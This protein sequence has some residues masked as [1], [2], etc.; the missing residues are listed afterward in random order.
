MTPE[1]ALTFFLAILVFAITP[2]PGV[3]ALLSRALVHG[4]GACVGLALGMSAGDLVYLLLACFGLAA[5]AEHAQG[6]FTLI[7]YLGAGYLFYLAWRLWRTPPPDPGAA[8][9]PATPR[10]RHLAGFVQGFLISTSNPKVILFYIAF[11]PTFMDLTRLT[12]VDIGVAA[13]LTLLALM[14]G[15]M[16]V[17][18]GAD[19]ARR[20]LATPAAARGLQRGA[21]GLMAA[22]GL[23]L[24]GRGH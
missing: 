10:G 21:G 13:L 7:R 16:S 8:A 5:V 6:L 20:W 19:S 15:L 23:W 3:F 18:W 1:S 4:Q 22:A 17:A 24:I 12:P 2:G 14:L 11:L 9:A